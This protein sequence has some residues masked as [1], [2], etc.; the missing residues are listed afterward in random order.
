MKKTSLIVIVIV[1]VAI[2]A[3]ALAAGFYFGNAQG[4]KE[5]EKIAKDELRPLVN[6]AFPPPEEKIMSLTGVIKG[7]YGAS[8]DFEIVAPSDYLPHLDGSPQKKEL[9]TASVS[10]S[11]E[12]VQMALDKQGNTKITTI[13]ISDLKI[14][15]TITAR[16]SV[17][18]KTAKKFDATRIELLKY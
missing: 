14:G 7:V 11:T 18:I 8:V 12:I 16:S 6:L 4:R 17:N 9:R 5:G 15:D 3:V 13:K 2:A 1:F 10:Q